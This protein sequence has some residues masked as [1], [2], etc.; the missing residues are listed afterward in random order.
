MYSTQLRLLLSNI[1]LHIYYIVLQHQI[2][3]KLRT[4]FLKFSWV[5]CALFFITLLLILILIIFRWTKFYLLI[6]FY[7]HAYSIFI[8][9]L[10]LFITSFLHSLT[11]SL[12]IS[13]SFFI[14]SGGK[15]IQNKIISS[16]ANSF[17]Y[18]LSSSL[19]IGQLNK[20]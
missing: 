11:L 16:S 2:S 14:G 3:E 1:T 13:F 4:F 7:C 15:K 12:L 18:I 20:P 5:C 9:L 19:P 8:L 17:V 6:L 10:S